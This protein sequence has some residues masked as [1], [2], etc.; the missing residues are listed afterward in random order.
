KKKKKKKKKKKSEEG[1]VLRRSWFQI[2]KCISEIDVLHLMRS[3]EIADLSHL[4]NEADSGSHQIDPGSLQVCARRHVSVFDGIFKRHNGGITHSGVGGGKIFADSCKLD[5]ESIVHFCVA[6]AAV[7]AVEL[8]D[9]LTPRVFSLRKLVEVAH[10]NINHRIPL[11]WQRIWNVLAPHFVKAGLHGN[12]AIGEYSVNSLRQLAGLFFDKEE[13]TNFQFQS[14]FLVPFYQIMQQSKTQT[15]RLLI[16]ECI[17]SIVKTKFANVKSG[18]KTVFSVISL[19]AKD[20]HELLVA[21]SY[22]IMDSILR[23]YFPLLRHKLDVLPSEEL[24]KTSELQETGTGGNSLR[25]SS[26]VQ[27]FGAETL[28]ECVH[29]LIAF[30]SNIYTDLSLKAVANIVSCANHL[31]DLDLRIKRL[32]A[33]EEP[34]HQKEQVENDNG[35][36]HEKKEH[37]NKHEHECES[38]QK[39]QEREQEQGQGQEKQEEKT[40]E[41]EKEQLKQVCLRDESPMFKAWFLCLTGLSRLVF[42]GRHKVR[43]AALH[44]LFNVLQHNGTK[45]SPQLWALIFRDVLFPMLKS[46]YHGQIKRLIRSGSPSPTDATAKQKKRAR[47]LSQVD[48]D[49]PSNNDD[50][51]S[52]QTQAQIQV[53]SLKSF[54]PSPPSSAVVFSRLQTSS[55]TIPIPLHASRLH[56]SSDDRSRGH[57]RTAIDSAVK[58]PETTCL[59]CLV[60]LVSLFFKFFQNTR[61]ILKKICILLKRGVNQ[62]S[63]KTAKCS[64]KCW[65]MLVDSVANAMTEEE[66][67]IVIHSMIS[68]ANT[69]LPFSRLRQPQQEETNSKQGPSKSLRSKGLPQVA[70]ELSIANVQK[71]VHPLVIEYLFQASLI[72]CAKLNPQQMIRI[73]T[74]LEESYRFARE[75]NT[76]EDWKRC[77]RSRGIHYLFYLNPLKKNNS[78]SSFVQR[79]DRRQ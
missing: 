57:L 27:L 56:K 7:S 78:Y 69:T 43:Q 5:S 11:I 15:I 62:A 35:G 10:D 28:N 67:T 42:D 55:N 53:Q 76:E 70:D 72:H 36:D 8:E 49:V 12:V 63:E 2:L 41:K 60:E 77:L 73:I 75:F 58:W 74:C 61:S 59:D 46:I 17:H 45:F 33:E 29:C 13:L 71:V 40:T 64:V 48:V 18:W 54:S 32:K 14:K 37:Q 66:W 65:K 30:S 24:I 51:D 26:P 16:V 79:P 44:S 3:R 50:P 68:S 22:E 1:N 31:Y 19:A 23:D 20:P 9:T 25:S 4:A 34:L 6:L 47:H 38:E 52:L 21:K 39:Q